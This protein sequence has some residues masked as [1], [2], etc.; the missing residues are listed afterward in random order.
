VPATMRVLGDWNWWPSGRSRQAVRG[1]K[2]APAHVE[3]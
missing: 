2:S 1:L 3:D